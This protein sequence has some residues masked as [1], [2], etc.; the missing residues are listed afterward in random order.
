MYKRFSSSFTI[1]WNVEGALQSTN[2]M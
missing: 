2:G 1:A